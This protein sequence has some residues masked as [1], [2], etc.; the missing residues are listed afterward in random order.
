[1]NVHKSIQTSQIHSKYLI[2]VSDSNDAS[3][4]KKSNTRSRQQS[5]KLPWVPR[6][7]LYTRRTFPVALSDKTK[8]T[9]NVNLQPKSKKVSSQLSRSYNLSLLHMHLKE[10]IAKKRYY[11]INVGQFFVTTK[12][13]L[14]NFCWFLISFIIYLPFLDKWE[15]SKRIFNQNCTADL[16][17]PA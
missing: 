13:E 8:S 16:L 6:N 12:I 7:P 17:C 2:I 14:I 15:I 11:E 5:L 1:M 9:I 3:N 4:K 10:A